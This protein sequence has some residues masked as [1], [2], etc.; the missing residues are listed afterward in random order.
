MVVSKSVLLNLARASIEEVLQAQ[1]TI[2]REELLEH[3]PILSTPMGVQVTLYLDEKI[4]GSS[5]SENADL[6]L[7]ESIILHAKLAAFQDPSFTPIATSE[8]LHASIELILYSPDGPLSHR[9]EPIIQ[10]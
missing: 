9:D 7:L 1:T 8:Y 4:R 5:K 2:N 10:E 6:P 3:Y